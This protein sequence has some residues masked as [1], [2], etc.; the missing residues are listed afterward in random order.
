[1]EQVPSLLA[2]QALAYEISGRMTVAHSDN[3]SFP[4]IAYARAG[5]TG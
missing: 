5:H 3:A 4:Q 2:A 1:M